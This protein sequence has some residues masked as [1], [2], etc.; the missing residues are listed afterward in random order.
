MTT[1]ATHALVG[2]R[3]REVRLGMLQRGEGVRTKRASFMAGQALTPGERPVR[4]L[5]L[6]RIRVAR[7]AIIRAS[8]GIT[9]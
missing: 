5:T 8:A 4:E 2:T 1:T 3:Q 7:S 6:V 9:M